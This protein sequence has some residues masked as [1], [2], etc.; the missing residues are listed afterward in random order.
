MDEVNKIEGTNDIA[1]KEWLK[2]MY[3]KRAEKEGR[4]LALFHKDNSEIEEAIKSRGEIPNWYSCQR[5]GLDFCSADVLI[6]KVSEEP[7]CKIC[8]GE[9]KGD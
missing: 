4:Q 8:S 7:I 9:I 2:A 3:Q 5:C 1:Y 6:I